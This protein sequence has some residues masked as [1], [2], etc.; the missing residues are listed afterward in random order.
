[1]HSTSGPSA[2]AVP[3]A[4]VGA[5][6]K[7]STQA[8]SCDTTYVGP[9]RLPISVHGTTVQ[10]SWL[11]ADNDV[12][13]Y[14][15]E[16]QRYDVT[17]VWQFA[18]HDVVTKPEAKEFLQSEGT[19]RVRVRGLFCGDSVGGFTDW[20]VFSTDDHN[21]PSLPIITTPP[22]CPSSV[23]GC[24]PP[25]CLIDCGPVDPP[26]CGENE[27]LSDGQCV[28]NGGGGDDDNP[29]PFVDVVFCHVE[30]H[31]HPHPH[32]TSQTKTAHSQG[33]LDAHVGHHPFDH[34][35]SCNDD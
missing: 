29:P 26:T 7:F 8:V 14:E 31:E 34:L 13:G 12:R 28:P 25:P 1:L 20:V 11:G 22:I 3:T 30:F 4:P 2:V 18:L 21:T 9:I 35:G 23:E 32:F 17:N 24:Y 6:G 19:Y 27:H 16:F 10:L 33:E 15:L 5:G